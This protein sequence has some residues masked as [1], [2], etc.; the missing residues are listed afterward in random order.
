M[1]TKMTPLRSLRDLGDSSPGAKDDY[2]ATLLSNE[3]PS[4]LTEEQKAA[5]DRDF[6]RRE[7]FRE[8]KLE[9][10][11][12]PSDPRARAMLAAWRKAHPGRYK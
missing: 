7:A 5:I 3:R 12:E 11:A 4:P 9:S 1:T 6:F 2:E 8:G 10:A